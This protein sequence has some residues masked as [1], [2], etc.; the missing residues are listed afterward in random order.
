MCRNRIKVI[1]GAYKLIIK[2]KKKVPGD[3]ILNQQK[4][5][6]KKTNSEKIEKRADFAQC[7]S[8]TINFRLRQQ[9]ARL[10]GLGI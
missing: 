2:R 9:Q 3:S 7:P 8:S 6:K 4:K 5:K 10:G 1:M